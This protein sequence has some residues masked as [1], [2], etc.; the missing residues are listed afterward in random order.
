MPTT[1]HRR[2][3]WG[4][5]NR[6]GVWLHNMKLPLMIVATFAGRGWV[7]WQSRSSKKVWTTLFSSSPHFLVCGERVRMRLESTQF[8][9]YLS[10]KT[11]CYTAAILFLLFLANLVLKGT[12]SVGQWYSSGEFVRYH[13]DM[14]PPFY[15]DR[16]SR[17]VSFIFWLKPMHRFTSERA[18]FTCKRNFRLFCRDI[19]PRQSVSAQRTTTLAVVPI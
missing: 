12:R 13:M 11:F 8:R 2:R 3:S 19:V 10:R 1:Q 9:S 17:A 16:E 14:T 7:V 4:W 5:V 6:Q 15:N 18:Y